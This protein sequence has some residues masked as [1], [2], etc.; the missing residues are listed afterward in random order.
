MAVDT[1]RTDS[2]PSRV[3]AEWEERPS[4]LDALR[5]F[6]WVVVL[7]GLIGAGLGVAYGLTRDEVYTADAELSVGRVDVATQAIPGFVAASRTLAD[8]YS[9]AISAKKVVD[10]ISRRTG[11]S[12]AE[13]LDQ[14]TASPIPNTATMQ[15]VAEGGSSAGAVRAANV[16]SQTL[17]DYVQKTN[18]FNPQTGDLLDRYRR[19]A[20]KFSAAQIART[21]AVRNGTV[22]EQTE[23]QANLLEA[24]LQMKAAASLYGSSQAG[25]ASPNTLLLLA[26]AGTAD[27]DRDTTTQQAGFAGLVGGILLGGL[28]ALLF[29]GIFSRRRTS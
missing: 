9:R 14:V 4:T 11:L 7:T 18:R 13:V 20:A 2:T 15:V 25:Q 6:W 5:R 27:G 29:A 12:G 10:R 23:T 8:T 19:A 17:V 24:K 21:A 16:A 3:P 22:P 28:L 1:E 26:P